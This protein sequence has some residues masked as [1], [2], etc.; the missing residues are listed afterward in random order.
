MND[1]MSFN[2]EAIAHGN[3]AEGTFT[4]GADLYGADFRA[5]EGRRLSAILADFN[6]ARDGVAGLGRAGWLLLADEAVHLPGSFR[7]AYPEVG[8]EVACLVEEFEINSDP[9]MRAA[10]LFDLVGL[11]IAFERAAHPA[12]FHT[13]CSAGVDFLTGLANRGLDH[14]EACAIADLRDRWGIAPEALLQ[15]E[16][17][18]V[19]L[20]LCLSPM[21]HDRDLEGVL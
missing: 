8:E 14:E 19:G 21:G 1:S 9:A 17:V 11:L 3:S 2:T 16:E 10:T 6:T 5:A 4:T 18:L 12:D 7:V 20:S 13:A 15:T